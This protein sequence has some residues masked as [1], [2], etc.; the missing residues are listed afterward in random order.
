MPHVPDPNDPVIITYPAADETA[1][2]AS[3]NSDVHSVILKTGGC[4]TEHDINVR[5]AA[6]S[7]GLPIG[8]TINLSNQTG[9]TVYLGSNADMLYG[10]DGEGVIGFM[11]SE[12]TFTCITFSKLTADGPDGEVHNIELFVGVQ[13]GDTLNVTVN[14]VAVPYDSE[15]GGYVYTVTDSSPINQQTYNI[16]VTLKAASAN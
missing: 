16:V 6:P 2:I 12:S 13:A 10:P 3:L 11:V 4:I 5:Y 7:G 1:M 9:E 15:S 8:N 14:N